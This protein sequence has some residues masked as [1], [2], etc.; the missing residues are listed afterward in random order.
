MTKKG[1][2]APLSSGCCSAFTPLVDW[3]CSIPKCVGQS[4][5]QWPQVGYSR[6]CADALG[7]DSRIRGDEK[8]G[9]PCSKMFEMEGL[10]AP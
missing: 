9:A 4:A 10:A 5:Q 3:E 7:E 6:A 8:L 1:L 2:D